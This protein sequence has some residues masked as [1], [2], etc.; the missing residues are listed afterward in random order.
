ML[1]WR[2]YTESCTAL[3]SSILAGTRATDSVYQV[4]RYCIALSKFAVVFRVMALQR[5]NSSNFTKRET[6]GEVKA[7]G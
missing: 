4:V 7:T 6:V 3:K 1:C 2:R 5:K